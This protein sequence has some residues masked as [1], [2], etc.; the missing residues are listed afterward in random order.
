MEG[1]TPPMAHL[2]WQSEVAEFLFI[3][4]DHLWNH[5]PSVYVS[6][7]LEGLSAHPTLSMSLDIL[8]R[9]CAQSRSLERH[10]SGFVRAACLS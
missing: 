8:F 10:W 7:P 3:P 2:S 9:G 1:R 6:W 4:L 5:R